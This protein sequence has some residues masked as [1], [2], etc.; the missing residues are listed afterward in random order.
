M[1]SEFINLAFGQILGMADLSKSPRF[2]GPSGQ[3]PRHLCSLIHWLYLLQNRPKILQVRAISPAPLFISFLSAC[4]NKTKTVWFRSTKNILF[5]FKKFHSLSSKHKKA[6]R[7][8][9]Y[10]SFWKTLWHKYLSCFYKSVTVDWLTQG[11][12]SWV[13][14]GHKS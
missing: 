1:D 8:H 14:L 11:R 5:D 2:L 10:G 13:V 4:E 6:P 12:I 3:A 7:T 9:F